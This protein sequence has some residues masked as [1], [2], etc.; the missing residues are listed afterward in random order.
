[1]HRLTKYAAK[2]YPRWW[3]ERYGEEFAALLEDVRPGPAGTLDI[4]K[5][6]LT[7]QLNTSSAKRLLL[8]ATATG[9]V[10]GVVAMLLAGP[11][12]SSA[13]AISAG[14]SD[15]AAVNVRAQ[16]MYSF[17][18]LLNLDRNLDLYRTERNQMPLE[19]VLALYRKNLRISRTPGG[20]EI[21]FLYRD[22]AVAQRT[23]RSIVAEFQ[24]MN[25]EVTRPPSL[26]GEAQFPGRWAKGLTGLAEGMAF[27]CG[28]AMLV[29][30]SR[31]ITP[32]RAFASCVGIS[33]IIGVIAFL[34]PINA[35]STAILS[36][37]GFDD[38]TKLSA[39]LAQAQSGLSDEWI[40]AT[41]TELNM[42]R[43]VPVADAVAQV[44]RNLRITPVEYRPGWAASIT[45]TEREQS[46]FDNQLRRDVQQFVMRAGR[47]LAET[48]QLA[49]G[50]FGILD[51]AAMH[52]VG[53]QAYFVFAPAIGLI[54]GAIWALILRLQRGPMSSSWKPV[55]GCAAVGVFGAVSATFFVTP[56]YSSEGVVA[57]RSVD[58]ATKGNI[59]IGAAINASSREVLTQGRLT[60]L[61]KDLNLYRE[62]RNQMPSED[63]LE[64][65]KRNIRISATR[66]VI[67]GQ[68]MPGFQISFQYPDK[69]VV[70]KVVRS[71]VSG[72]IDESLRPGGASGF[73]LQALDIGLTPDGP[74]FPRRTDFA[75]AGLGAGV[76]M[77]GI[78]AI[79]LHFRRKRL[80]RFPELREA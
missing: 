14:S 6:A 29:Y 48:D 5:G 53:S 35:A 56:Q 76:L 13:A 40:R 27:V 60:T 33:L 10:A 12:Y 58:G 19:D 17:T 11:S 59:D 45:L 16:E 9:V 73:T 30:F 43:G 47:R 25:V 71:L 36:T 15:M 7:M 72:F 24:K 38:P 51:S 55:L 41:I 37:P 42:Y 63:V 18:A 66:V 68:M 80:P 34:I 32:L 70:S 4:L 67:G 26:P 64:G 57:M 39:R 75:A 28:I 3:R 21:E 79:I 44:R 2:L 46:K 77:G 52:S 74:V 54:V 31:R 23:V 20:L 22:K 78:I 8:L 62:E 50:T 65:M 49:G 69:D 1:M 61:I